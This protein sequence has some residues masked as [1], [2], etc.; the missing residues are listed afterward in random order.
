MSS[1][2]WSQVFIGAIWGRSGD[3]EEDDKRVR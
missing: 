1:T 2:G 3:L